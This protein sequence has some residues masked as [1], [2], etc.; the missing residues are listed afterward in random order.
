M[1]E[2]LLEA[3]A[4]KLE[5]EL[6]D[7]VDKLKESV[8]EAVDQ[9]KDDTTE[10]ELRRCVTALKMKMQ[11]DKEDCKWL[12]DTAGND[13][14]KEDEYLYKSVFGL[15]VQDSVDSILKREVVNLTFQMS[16][17]R[18]NISWKM[19]TDETLTDDTLLNVLNVPKGFEEA[20]RVWKEQ[21]KNDD[22]EELS[23]QTLKSLVIMGD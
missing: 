12:L 13:E 10:E 6:Q 9:K 11:Q 21:D 14:E 4:L 5:T 19:L 18:N 23:Y 20:W 3:D 22:Q 16:L 1:A 2:K 17:F 15:V 7:T 8:L